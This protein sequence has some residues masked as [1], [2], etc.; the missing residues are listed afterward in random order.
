MT[1]IVFHATCFSQADNMIQ[2]PTLGVHFFL[3]DF[4][5]ALNIRSSSLA[6]ALTNKQFGKM[7]DMSPGLAVNYIRGL[8]SHLDFTSTLAVSSLGYPRQHQP[9]DDNGFLFETD[10]SVRAKMVSNKYWFI[11]Y[12][13]AGVGVS[14]FK[15]YWGAFVPA[16]VGIQ[17]GFFNEAYLLVNSQYRIPVTENSNYHFFYSIGIAGNI[18]K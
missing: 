17:I 10:A 6:S 3:D 7:K 11:P 14:K 15:G 4:A 5:S 2:R 1:A 8:N 18:G 13:Q 12:I 16:G 9:A